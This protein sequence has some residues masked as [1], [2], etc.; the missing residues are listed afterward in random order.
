ML[1]IA[2][3]IGLCSGVKRAIKIIEEKANEKL[4]VIGDLIHNE[5]VLEKLN[6][7][8]VQNIGEVESTFVIRAHGEEL[9]VLEEITKKGIKTLDLTC[10]IVKKIHELAINLEREGY[11]VLIYG[12]SNH[13][14]IRA[15]TSRLK[16][17]K[18]ISSIKELEEIVKE[19]R[20]YALIEQTT[21]SIEKFEEIKAKFRNK[22]TI[23]NT[24]CP[25]VVKRQREVVEIA[26][27]VDLMVIIGS[28]RSANTNTLLEVAKKY[29]KAIR[30]NSAKELPAKLPPRIGIASGTSTSD[31][32]IEEVKNAI[33]G[34]I[35]ENN[36]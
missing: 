21:A 33:L 22:I 29:T 2:K 19:N 20:K 17:F 4:F 3:H 24:L 15:L 26:K 28:E 36:S 13:A 32:I 11:E 1:I 18:V 8:K 16:K 23:F 14:E 6:L 7:I 12:Q 34:K 31:E 10:P 5:R 27:K 35:Q 25:E 30:V 9:E